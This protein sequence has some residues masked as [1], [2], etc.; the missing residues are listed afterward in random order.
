MY[1]L[2]LKYWGHIDSDPYN[3]RASLLLI[4][5]EHYVNGAIMQT[6]RLER[7]RK[8]IDKKFR[9]EIDSIR[10][11]KYIPKSKRQDF[12][13][14]RLYCMYVVSESGTKWAFEVTNTL[15]ATALLPGDSIIVPSYL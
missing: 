14:I 8:A 13:L 4:H 5:L 6:G 10:T 1:K 12:S 11:T 15:E 2:A 3:H 9:E 7:T